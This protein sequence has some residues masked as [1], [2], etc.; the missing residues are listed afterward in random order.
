MAH[1]T[2][3]DCEDDNTHRFPG[4]LDS[5][6]PPLSSNSKEKQKEDSPPKP[7]RKLIQGELINLMAAAV[8]TALNLNKSTST[9]T[10]SVFRRNFVAQPADF[11]GK[12]EHYDTFNQSIQIWISSNP[13]LTSDKD[14]IYS[15]MGHKA[16]LI[17]VQAEAVHSAA[18]PW[19]MGCFLI[20]VSDCISLIV[21]WSILVS[22]S[23][24]FTTSLNTFPPPWTFVVYTPLNPSPSPTSEE[25]TTP[26]S[27]LTPSTISTPSSMSS[28]MDQSGS[29]SQDHQMHDVI[30]PPQDN[31][32]IPV[33][34]GSSKQSTGKQRAQL[35]SDKFRF[36]K[37]E[38]V[39]VLRLAV[40]LGI[41]LP[42]ASSLFLSP[43]SFLTFA[44]QFL[45]LV[46]SPK[47]CL[48]SFPLTFPYGLP[49]R[50]TPDIFLDLLQG[51]STPLLAIFL[52]PSIT[53]PLG[54]YPGQLSFLLV[55][56]LEHC[57][58]PSLSTVFPPPLVVFPH[59]VVFPALD[60]Q[61][62]DPELERKAREHLLTLTQGKKTAEEFFLT[63]DAYRTKGKLTYKEFDVF[64][65]E[66]LD[67]AL[68]QDLVVQIH[69]AY[70]T[71]KISYNEMKLEVYKN[72]VEMMK[73]SGKTPT[74]PTLQPD[75]PS[76]NVYRKLA[77]QLGPKIKRDYRSY[78]SSSY[79]P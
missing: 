54:L 16:V 66:R 60:A 70:E 28:S 45:S 3:S 79:F 30:I 50:F 52:T 65:V 43:L 68:N 39:E 9:T 4:L 6:D 24:Y 7:L 71:N 2:G 73:D 77:I 27:S 19:T 75:K 23:H 34:S 11:D 38:L 76:Y 35:S 48:P 32:Q 5:E 72:M 14:K 55:F 21:S 25:T 46:L 17:T 13:T 37:D 57:V 36:S 69:S 20:V 67:H 10:P 56:L 1:Q 42:I 53:F 8:T 64:L 51:L 31:G 47:P 15:V 62:I 49:L 61:F 40:L 63:F 44:N 41:A 58:L 22:L 12:R 74:Y 59:T 33:S 18:F 26:P 29:S 78:Q